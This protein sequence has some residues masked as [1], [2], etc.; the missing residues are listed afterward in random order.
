MAMLLWFGFEIDHY[1]LNKFLSVHFHGTV[2]TVKITE[3]STQQKFL[4]L[5]YGMI[6]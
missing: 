5:W 1:F 4:N 3:V 2:A 6:A